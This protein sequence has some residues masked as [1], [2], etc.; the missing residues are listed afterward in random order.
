MEYKGENVVGTF[1]NVPIFVRKFSIVTNFT[2]MENM[3]AYRDKDM[4]DVIFGK[5]FCRDACVEARRFD[6]FITIHNGNDNVTYQMARSH[7]MFKHLSN[8]QCNKIRPLLKVS[9]RDILEENLHP[10]QKLKGFYKGF[11]NLGPEYIRGEKTVEWPTRGHDS[12]RLYFHLHHYQLKLLRFGE[13]LGIQLSHVKKSNFRGINEKAKLGSIIRS[14]LVATELLNA[15]VINDIGKLCHQE[16]IEKSCTLSS[17]FQSPNPNPPKTE[18]NVHPNASKRA[19]TT[20][21]LAMTQD[22]IRKLVADS[23]TSALEAQVRQWQVLVIP[24]GTPWSYWNS[25]S[26]NG[27]LQRVHELL[28]YSTLMIRKELTRAIIEDLSKVFKKLAKPLTK[29]PEEQSYSWSEEQ[30]SAF[31]SLKQNSVKSPILALP[32]RKR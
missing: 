23:V 20:E 25:Y 27:K 4:G 28:T 9:A 17:N 1:T 29:L 8:E 5:P 14:P 13:I 11:L 16:D 30:E 3:N 22:A 12:I 21:A 32:E 2:V 7:P 10:Y 31:N 15:E 24:T 18:W 19:S 26:E 6:R